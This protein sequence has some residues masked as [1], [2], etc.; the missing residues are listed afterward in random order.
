M[1]ADRQCLRVLPRSAQ[2]AALVDRVGNRICRLV[3]DGWLAFGC[4]SEHLATCWATR[5]IGAATSTTTLSE[6][7]RPSILR[8]VRSTWTVAGVIHT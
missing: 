5:E 1:L 6:K 2:L 4:S 3:D 7:P 8:A